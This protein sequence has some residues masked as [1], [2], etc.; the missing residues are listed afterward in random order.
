MD[1][2]E[3]PGLLLPR[4]AVTP[5]AT[6]GLATVFFL[7]PITTASHMRAYETALCTIQR[8]AE[9]RSCGRRKIGLFA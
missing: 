4:G 1:D 5:H 7:S 8:P 2:R 9:R 3:A 6:S